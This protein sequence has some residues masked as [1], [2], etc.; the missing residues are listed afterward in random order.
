MIRV[1]C[2]CCG[3]AI[4]AEERLAGQT[5]RCP[6]CL[7]I[8][9]VQSSRPEDFAQAV[10]PNY[11]PQPH[12][13]D[14]PKETDCPKC[15]NHLAAGELLCKKCGYHTKLEA[16]FE[17]L[18]TESLAKGTEPKTK[19]ERWLESQLHERATPRDFLIISAAC[20]LFL[21]F[22]V[23]LTARILAGPLAGTIA[24]LVM[25]AGIALAWY[26]LMQQLGVMNDPK[27]EIRLAREASKKLET[28]PRQPGKGRVVQEKAASP[29]PTAS[30][31]KPSKLE[32]PE[33]DVDDID[34]FDD[35]PP[36]KR[37]KVAPAK[38]AAAPAK[39]AK[40]AKAAPAASSSPVPSRS[41]TPKPAASKPHTPTDDD[42]LNDLL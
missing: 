3:A 40:A 4:K 21:C 42:W 10:E 12:D 39:P 2:P 38:P 41:V 30:S 25:S 34:L 6:K 36:K 9:R 13:D 20:G 11:A 7:S 8:A 1:T 33:Y 26:V 27:R 18:T 22:V 35:A 37:K 5:I 32:L 19:G 15:G 17:D 16:F 14:K 29:L 24:G 28:V 23:I 31:K